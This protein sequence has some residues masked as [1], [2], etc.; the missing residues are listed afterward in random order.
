MHAPPPIR[1]APFFPPMPAYDTFNHK[2]L[3]CQQ[4][5]RHY[6][7]QYIKVTSLCGGGGGYLGHCCYVMQ[8]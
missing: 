5:L 4:K 6:L 7:G 8:R 2:V 3:P 1:S